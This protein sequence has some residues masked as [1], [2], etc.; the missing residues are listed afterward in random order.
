M[1]NGRH[2]RNP[3]IHL[4]HIHQAAH[5]DDVTAI[6]KAAPMGTAFTLL[7]LTAPAAPIIPHV[8]AVPTMVQRHANSDPIFI[9]AIG[10]QV[11]QHTPHI[12][13][14]PFRLIV[15]QRG[16]KAGI[17]QIFGIMH[18]VTTYQVKQPIRG[19]ANF[20]VAPLIHPPTIVPARG[21]DDVTTIPTRIKAITQLLY[22]GKHL[23]TRVP[24]N[25]VRAL[26]RCLKR[27]CAAIITI[28][29]VVP[30]IKKS[31]GILMPHLPIHIQHPN[32]AIGPGSYGD[33]QHAAPSHQL[34]VFFPGAHRILQPIAG[35]GVF[36]RVYTA[37][38]A[39]GAGSIFT[40]A[41][42]G[43]TLKA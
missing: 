35:G 23:A 31:S 20:A 43:E 1:F 16:R 15:K 42:D 4:G 30:L 22:P 9:T 38:V 27:G 10:I 11:R 7:I 29:G 21:G 28:C 8:D 40:N 25:D 41:M 32:S 5:G 34:F 6:L 3:T 24:V 2:I 14:R 18:D 19:L 17:A 37:G 26:T 12:R 13:I 33:V 39:A 36:S